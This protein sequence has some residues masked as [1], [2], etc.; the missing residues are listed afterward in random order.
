LEL[1]GKDFNSCCEAFEQVLAFLLLLIEKHLH[2]H[3]K[4]HTSPAQAYA[5]HE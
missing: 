3:S 1:R 2:D 5:L 4:D